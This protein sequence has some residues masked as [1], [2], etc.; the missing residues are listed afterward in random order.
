MFSNNS[1]GVTLFKVMTRILMHVNVNIENMQLS[2][3]SIKKNKHL[4][5]EHAEPKS[6]FAKR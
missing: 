2:Y 1:E 4:L 3:K 6:E 5:G